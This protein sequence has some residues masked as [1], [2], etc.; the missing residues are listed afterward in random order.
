MIRTVPNLIPQSLVTEL[1]EELSRLELM[2]GRR[3]A[4]ATGQDK[5]N[6]LQLVDTPEALAMSQKISQHLAQRRA[7][8]EMLALR[9]SLPFMFNCY[10]PG[11][12]YKPHRDNVIM[13]AKGHELRVDLSATVFLSEPDSYDGGELVV[14]VDHRPTPVKLPAGSMVLYPGNSVHAVTPVTR[15]TRWA[16]VTWFQSRIR[17]HEQRDAYALI[18]HAKTLLEASPASTAEPQ[19]TALEQVCRVQ[20]E[21]LRMW[22]E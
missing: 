2:E 1:V 7:V 11:M 8:S 12:E 20:D 9:S 6:N 10:R 21:L 17:S 15:G 18:I 14:D 13:Y 3:T 19:K 4:G 5:K 22:A 16:A